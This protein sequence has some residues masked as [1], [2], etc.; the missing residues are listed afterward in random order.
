MSYDAFAAVIAVGSFILA[1]LAGY[2]IGYSKGYEDGK[3][4]NRR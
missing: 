3:N 2:L 4:E 1:G